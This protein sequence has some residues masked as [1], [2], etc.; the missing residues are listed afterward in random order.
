MRGRGPFLRPLRTM[1]ASVAIPPLSSSSSSSSSSGH[2]S[3]P[4]P[5][6]GGLGRLAVTVATAAGGDVVS[7]S[8]GEAGR[9]FDGRPRCSSPEGRARPPVRSCSDALGAEMPVITSRESRPGVAASPARGVSAGADAVDGKQSPVSHASRGSPMLGTT[10]MACAGVGATT[11]GRNSQPRGR[12]PPRDR[13]IFSRFWQAWSKSRA[14]AAGGAASA[15][16]SGSGTDR[17]RQAT[18]AMRR[19]R[20]GPPSSAA[21]TL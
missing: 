17:G 1:A 2:P 4:G 16:G 11:W 9:P 5:K 3:V 19:M 21:S 10:P 6:A 12:P 7:G 15:A 18:D 13:P 8:V 20:G 14:S